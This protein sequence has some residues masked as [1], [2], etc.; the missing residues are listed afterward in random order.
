MYVR[1]YVCMYRLLL[2]M[3]RSP[4]PWRGAPRFADGI[5]TP[6]PKPQIFCELVF[7]IGFS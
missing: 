7:L 1:T 3:R 4:R 5:G 6:D 2:S